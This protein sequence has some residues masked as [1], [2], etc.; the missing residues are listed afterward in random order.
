MTD[1]ENIRGGKA[2]L[3]SLPATDPM[4]IFGESLQDDEDPRVV[5]I[6]LRRLIREARP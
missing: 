4:R 5:D 1:T 3:R 2:A 6:L